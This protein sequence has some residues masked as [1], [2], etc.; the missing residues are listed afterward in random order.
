MFDWIIDAIGWT[1][2]ALVYQLFGT[3]LEKIFYWPDWLFLRPITCG[4][5]P[6]QGAVKHNRFGVGLFAVT[7]AAFAPLLYALIT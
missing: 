6:P 7:L 4:G 5:Y 1:I 3:L 2:R